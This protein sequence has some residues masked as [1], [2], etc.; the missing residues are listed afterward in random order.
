LD[1]IIKKEGY[2]NLKTLIQTKNTQGDEAIKR[3]TAI[4]N[5]FFGLIDRGYDFEKV[6]KIRNR[7]LKNLIKKY[8]ECEKSVK[9]KTEEPT[10]HVDEVTLRVAS[11]YEK[12]RGIIDW[13]E[14]HLLKRL[15]VRSFVVIGVDHYI[16]LVTTGKDGIII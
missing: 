14:E 4:A 6:K 2:T 5:V 11:F 1:E 9:S 8:Q 12:I 10:I 16:G 13:K 7:T 15:V 3:A